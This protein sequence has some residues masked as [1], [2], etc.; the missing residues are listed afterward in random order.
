MSER[1]RPL[2]RRP[3][4]YCKCYFLPATKHSKVCDKCQIKNHLKKNPK[5]LNRKYPGRLIPRKYDLEKLGISL[6]E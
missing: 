5:L 2:M 3:C 4:K 6:D 1:K